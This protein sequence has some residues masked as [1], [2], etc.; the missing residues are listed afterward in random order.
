MLQRQCSDAQLTKLP[1]FKLGKR[2]AEIE[3]ARMFVK[4]G[5]TLRVGGAVY[6]ND[7]AL[8][9]AQVQQTLRMIGVIVRLQNPVEAAWREAF[10][11]VGQAAVDQ[12][13]L[14]AA[15]DQRAARAAAQAGIAARQSARRAL[16]AIHRNLPRVTGAQ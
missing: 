9:P 13:A 14:L 15:L 16:A 10:A 8:A 12:P 6:R 11:E 5:Q 1:C 3:N 2:L 4:V 7:Q